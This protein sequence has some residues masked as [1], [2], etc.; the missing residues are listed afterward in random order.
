MKE[1]YIWY[2][3]YGSNLNRERFMCYIGGGR[4]KGSE[5]TEVGCTDKTPPLLEE[6]DIIRYPLYFAKRSN[7]WQKQ[8]VA[9]IGLDEEEDAQTFSKR[10]LITADQFHDVVKQENNGVELELNFDEIIRGRYQKVRESWYGTIIHLGQHDGIP[11][12]TFTADWGLDVAFTKPSEPYVSM[13]ME[14]LKTIEG[15]RHADIMNYLLTKPGIIGE[16]TKEEL[17]QL[18]R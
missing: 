9:F 16:Y 17:E 4:P 18:M 10:Y 5:K 6:T 7:R 13:I 2:A 1:T 11:V 15:L 12:F 14:G 3:S 8:G